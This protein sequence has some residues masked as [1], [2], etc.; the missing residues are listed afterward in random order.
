MVVPSLC[1]LILILILM[2]CVL[3]GP[4]ASQNKQDPHIRCITRSTTY[5][6]RCSRP[7]LKS[8]GMVEQG[9]VRSNRIGFL[10][11]SV[12]AL[13]LGD[14]IPPFQVRSGTVC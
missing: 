12:L 8:N 11:R 10:T 14:S 13:R 2:G 6:T 5:L 9:L 4:A 7:P 3:V 1:V